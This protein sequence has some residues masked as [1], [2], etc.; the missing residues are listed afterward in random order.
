LHDFPLHLWGWCTL[1]FWVGLKSSSMH[2]HIFG[3]S[4]LADLHIPMDDTEMDGSTYKYY[5]GSAVLVVA[6]KAQLAS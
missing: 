6:N 2:W 3:Y 4:D 5:V 1:L